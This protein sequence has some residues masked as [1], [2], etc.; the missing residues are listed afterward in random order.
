MGV[1]RW[2]D[3]RRTTCRPNRTRT[4]QPA[5]SGLIIPLDQYGVLN[6][7]S[8][9]PHDF[10]GNDVA[11]AKLLGANA[12]VAFGR[13]GRERLL[14]HQTYR[15]EFLNAILR[16]DVLNAVTVIRDRVAIVDCSGTTV[17]RR[18]ARSRPNGCRRR[19]I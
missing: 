17:S 1:R 3:N 4:T 13:S 9:E 12:Q 15:M 5:R 8:W 10:D 2:R 6:V 11:L 19:A 16:H 7:G 18:S 14:E